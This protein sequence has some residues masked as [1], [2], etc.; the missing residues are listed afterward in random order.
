MIYLLSYKTVEDIK[1]N[2]LAETERN[3]KIVIQ[4]FSL[5]TELHSFHKH[6]VT[7]YKI[8]YPRIP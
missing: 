6:Y 7:S 8:L 2:L 1:H 5:I 4:L 3:L